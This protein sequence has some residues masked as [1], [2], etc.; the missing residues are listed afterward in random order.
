MCII[1]ELSHHN[2]HS[3]TQC[4][5]A[6]YICVPVPCCQQWTAGS[7]SSSLLVVVEVVAGVWTR[8]CR[9]LTA[10][11]LWTR[12]GLAR[13]A[14]SLD[15]MTFR[16]DQRSST[17]PHHRRQTWTTKDLER[18]QRLT[19]DKTADKAASS[20][21]TTTSNDLNTDITATRC[22]RVSQSQGIAWLIVRMYLTH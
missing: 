9:Q 10:E 11:R 12:R 1:T 20:S 19:T 21:A 2:D 8:H 15:S 5:S 7:T 6:R 18:E 17:S 14:A 22:Y 3:V 13:R 16:R 4:S